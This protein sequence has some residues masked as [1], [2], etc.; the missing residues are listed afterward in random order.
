MGSKQSDN[1]IFLT[2]HGKIRLP[3]VDEICFNG[4]NLS[5]CTLEVKEC[6]CLNLKA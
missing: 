2:V 6:P 3:C 4:S 5:E 1:F